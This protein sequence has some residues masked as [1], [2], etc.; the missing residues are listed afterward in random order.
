MSTETSPAKDMAAPR[1]SR[2]RR[3]LIGGALVASGIIIGV[4]TSAMSQGYGRGGSDDDGGRYERFDGPR[5]SFRDHDGP[6]GWFRDHD[7]PRRWFGR[8]GRG[9]WFDRE[10]RSGWHGGAAFGGGFGGHFLTPGRIERMVGR[11]AWAVDASSEQK[12]KIREIVQRA[13]DDLRPLR[14]KHLDYRRQVREV[15]TAATIDRAKLDSL[16]NEHMKLA[17]QASQRITTALAEAAEV[18][19]PEQRADL[20]R[21]LERFGPRRG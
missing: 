15:L 7:G 19:T 21:R 11:L 9:G 20:G 1:T 8:E 10:G 17:D 12:Q 5:G 2:W 13:A 6:R 16:R 14:E 4:G 18:L 3:F